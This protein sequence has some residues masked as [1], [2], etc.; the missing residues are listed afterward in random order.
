M[1]LQ[2]IELQKAGKSKLFNLR[3]FCLGRTTMLIINTSGRV[4]ATPSP[5][6]YT[7]LATLILALVSEQ[8]FI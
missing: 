6:T 1:L 2:I 5:M 4:I 8:T 3:G 7:I